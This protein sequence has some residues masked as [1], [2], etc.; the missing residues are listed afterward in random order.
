MFSLKAHRQHIS[1]LLAF[2]LLCVFAIALTPWSSLHHHQE[3]QES[4]A[5]PGDF[6]QHKVHISKQQHNCL[7]CSAHFEKDYSKTSQ[8]PAISIGSSYLRYADLIAH[9]GYTALISQSLRGP[10]LY[11]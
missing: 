4:C 10:P 5:K 7:V 2:L 3:Q 6:C 8:T 9:A 11:S 1:Q